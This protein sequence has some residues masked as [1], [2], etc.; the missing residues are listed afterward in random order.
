MTAGTG[1]H[2]ARDIPPVV[3]RPAGHDD[4]EAIVEMV[5]ELA[6]FERA[7]AECLL[8]AAQLRV[9]LFGPA[10]AVFGHVATVGPAVVG[11]ALWML[12]FSTWRGVHG[13]HLEDLYVRPELRGH[14]V[15][16]RLLTA[17]AGMCVERGYGRL[18]WAVLD[19]NAPAA[20]FYRA[21]G[22]VSMDDWTTFR[23]DGPAL[24]AL[25]VQDS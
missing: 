24:A 22:A 7:A 25:G 20:G 14:G 23:L 4:V 13:V 21:L 3:L 15:G 9:A 1:P 2:A 10:P 8:T 17:L 5:H 6:A 11:C 18:E 12:D 16:R 19:W